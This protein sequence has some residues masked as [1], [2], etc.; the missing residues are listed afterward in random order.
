MGGLAVD[1]ISE[2]RAPG[3]MGWLREWTG[4]KSRHCAAA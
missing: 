3:M 2:R 4:V 1:S